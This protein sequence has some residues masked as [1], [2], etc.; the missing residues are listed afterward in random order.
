MLILEVVL[1]KSHAVA[2][3]ANDLLGHLGKAD[4]AG[5]RPLHSVERF[6]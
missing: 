4:D 3:E 6:P 2:K 1:L 5:L